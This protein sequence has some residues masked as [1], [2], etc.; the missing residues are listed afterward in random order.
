MEDPPVGTRKLSRAFRAAPFRALV[1]KGGW[2]D[3]AQRRL[4]WAAA[5]LAHNLHLRAGEKATRRSGSST[6]RAT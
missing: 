1:Q 6:A 4:K 3:T 5:L 2:W